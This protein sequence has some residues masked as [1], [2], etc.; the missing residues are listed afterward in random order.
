[1]PLEDWRSSVDE[2]TLV[3]LACRVWFEAQGLK[4]STSDLVK[5]T[6]L[7]VI[8]RHKLDA[9]LMRKAL[10]SMGAQLIRDVDIT[11]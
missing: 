6:E 7:V 8:Q 3:L 5:M 10:D 2:I 4:Y 9:G 1:M 11:P